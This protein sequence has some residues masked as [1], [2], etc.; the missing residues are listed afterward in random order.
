M[1]P[2]CHTQVKAEERRLARD[3]AIYARLRQAY[4][5][6][7]SRQGAAAGAVAAAARELRPVEI[8]GLYEAQREALEGETAGLRAEVGRLRGAGGIMHVL[9]AA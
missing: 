8:V 7:K 4:A 9:S 3:K 5:A 6:S 1:P 2:C